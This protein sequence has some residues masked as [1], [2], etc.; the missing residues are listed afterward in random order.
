MK[1]VRLNVK[2]KGNKWGSRFKELF[3]HYVCFSYSSLLPHSMNDNDLQGVQAFADLPANS[4]LIVADSQNRS[5]Q[6][7]NETP[8]S[9][10]AILTSALDCKEIFYNELVWNQPLFSHNMLNNELIFQISPDAGNTWNPPLVM[11]AMPY[12]C[13]TSFDGNKPG[14]CYQTPQ[15]NSYGFQM[16]YGLNNDVRLLSSNTQLVNGGKPFY[17]IANPGGSILSFFFR[18]SSS[19]GY[20]MYF[21]GGATQ[22]TFRLLTCTWIRNAHFVHGFGSWNSDLSQYGVYNNPNAVPP[23]PNSAYQ[24]N[25]TA[26]WAE[27]LPTLLPIRYVVVTT[28]ELT[29]D[30]KI[31]SYHSGTAHNFR[32]EIAV[33]P[34]SYKNTGVMH[35]VAAGNDTTTVSL[36]WGY[37]P[38]TFHIELNGEDGVPLVC[39]NPLATFLNSANLFTYSNGA[40]NDVIKLQFFSGTYGG[41]RAAPTTM[42][43]L[44]FGKPSLWSATAYVYPT[45]DWGGYGAQMLMEDVCH[46]MTAV[47]KFN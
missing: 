10:T 19:K 1:T 47:L 22:T 35:S 44:L 6:N 18:Y 38:Q 45:T 5:N 24:D 7:P 37:N 26:Y 4:S 46:T 34:V 11:Y 16:E 9:F 41:T 28:P 27:S 3:F 40:Y 25:T 42:N 12:V 21:T 29:K 14:S 2:E 20:V 33:L 8:S 23:I 39:G 17:N 30:R 36:R 32:N 15:G 13:Y 31:Q 43:L